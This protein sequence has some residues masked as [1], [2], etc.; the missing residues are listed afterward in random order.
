[1]SQAELERLAG[2]ARAEGRE[3]AAVVG[4]GFVGT[5]V[6]AALCAP[7][8]PG[9]FFVIGIERDTP[10]G[11]RKAQALHAGYAP[12]AVRDPSVEAAL[13]AAVREPRWLAATTDLEA[14]RHADVVL[15]CVNVDLERA[16]GQTEHLDVRLDVACAVLEEVGARL[17]P[18]GIA[19]VESTLPVGASERLLHPALLAGAARAGRDV[20]RDPPLYAY[21]YERVTPGPAYLDSVRRTPRT[22]AGID[23]P[24]AAR[25]RRFLARAM[26]LE[27]HPAWELPTT[28]AAELAKLLENAY[29]ATNI[30]F[31][32]EW[33]RL[34]E[35]VGVDLCEVVR[36]IRVRQGTHDNLMLP[37]L[38]VGGYCLTKDALLAAW[39][40]ESLL[41]VPAELPFSRRAILVNESMPLRALEA[42]ELHFQAGLAGVGAALFGITYRAGVE[43]T[44][45][46]PAETLARA[47]LARGMRVRAHDPLARAWP[48]LPEVALAGSPEEALVGAELACVCLPD[49]EYGAR[50]APILAERMPAGGLLVDAWNSVGGALAGRLAVRGVATFVYGRGDLPRARP[51]TPPREA[52]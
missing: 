11:R 3:I 33:A 13:A 27:C 9:T 35:R 6:A 7:S 42:A 32:D 48:E 34:A 31:V 51:G 43:D 15:V 45:N 5:A 49:A 25:A 38:G 50:L 44:R 26:D 37:G 52:R 22:F 21:C 24:S 19:I 2:E 46:S 10:D 18:G 29:R 17:R 8:G 23:A 30:A 41:Q 4:L 14:L 12:F 1:M 36:S 47:L 28:R 20:R 40:A 16:R 39:G